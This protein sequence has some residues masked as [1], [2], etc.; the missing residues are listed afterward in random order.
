MTNKMKLMSLLYLLELL[1]VVVS[2]YEPMYINRQEGL[3]RHRL[4]S[5]LR[6]WGKKESKLGFSTFIVQ[7]KKKVIG[8]E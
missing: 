8:S 7:C 4:D 3:L 2:V 1:L 5:R 6:I